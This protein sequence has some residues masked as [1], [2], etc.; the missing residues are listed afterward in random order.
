MPT[1][2]DKPNTANV[3]ASFSIRTAAL[4]AVVT[5]IST[6]AF[7]RATSRDSN[8]EAK[9]DRLEAKIDA[10]FDRLVSE[11]RRIDVRLARV[12]GARGAGNA[13]DD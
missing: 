12:E 10:R 6:S 3:S 13:G 2:S 1:S 7:T 11:Q 5:A 9:L 4:V 8:I